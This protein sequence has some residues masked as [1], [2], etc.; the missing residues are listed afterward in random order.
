VSALTDLSNNKIG[1]SSPTSARDVHCEKVLFV[2]L[3]P[4]F[5][6]CAVCFP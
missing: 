5:L 6:A 3:L 4:R 1:D 2:C